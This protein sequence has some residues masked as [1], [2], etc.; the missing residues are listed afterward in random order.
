MARG[1]EGSKPL[2]FFLGNRPVNFGIKG[3]TYYFQAVWTLASPH[4]LFQ[5]ALITFKYIHPMID[6]TILIKC[7]YYLQCPHFNH[8]LENNILVK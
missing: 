1:S 5:Q 8:K 2:Y 7:H 6:A 3:R 4:R